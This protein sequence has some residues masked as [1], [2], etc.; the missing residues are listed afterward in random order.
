[1]YSIHRIR[2]GYYIIR[3]LYGETLAECE[4]RREALGII[5]SMTK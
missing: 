5:W 3:N 1:M 4:T 2:P